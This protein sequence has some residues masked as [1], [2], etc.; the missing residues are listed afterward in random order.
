MSRAAR[1]MTQTRGGSNS[2]LL[3]GAVKT[4]FPCHAAKLFLNIL[5][6]SSYATFQT[7]SDR[8]ELKVRRADGK[9]VDP[10]ARVVH[11]T[12]EDSLKTLERLN[13]EGVGVFAMVN[14]GNGRGRKTDD[15]EWVRAI[16]V[17][18]DGAPYPTDLPLQ[19]HLIV[20]SSPGRFHIYWRVNGLNPGSFGTV[21]KA[22]ANLYGTDPS[23]KDL[24]RVMRLPGFHHHKA[25]PVMVELLEAARHAS[26]GSDVIFEAWPSLLERLEQERLTELEREQ[27]RKAITARAAERRA[28]PPSGSNFEGKLLLEAHHNTVAAASKGFRHDTLL[29]SA[30]A[31]GGYIAG[32]CFERA[33]VED[34]LLA[35]AEAC[36]LPQDEAAD[37][38]RWGLD[39]GQ[40][41]PLTFSGWEH[42]RFTTRQKPGRPKSRSSRVCNRMRGW[43]HGRA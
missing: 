1:L 2:T 10:N 37:A 18:T 17:D 25:E 41:E 34:A 40:A 35:A 22:L 39:N 4:R 26:Y 33:K 24:A 12:F 11:G 14:K 42:R 21:Q 28:D 36:G 7:F 19:P 8:D 16:F 30:R 31:L 23:V 9:L 3:K 29:R 20:E 13:R 27:R 43:R 38:I 32:G 6:G 15:V 5:A